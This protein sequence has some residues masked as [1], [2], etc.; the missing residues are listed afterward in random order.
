MRT[1]D[2]AYSLPTE[3]I[4]ALSALSIRNFEVTSLRYFDIGDD[5]T[6]HYLDDSDIAK[7]PTPDK[8]TSNGHGTSASIR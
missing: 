8:A 2:F 4:F 7:I 5:G 1:A 6:L 3:L